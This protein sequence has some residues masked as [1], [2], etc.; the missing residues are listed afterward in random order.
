MYD[1]LKEQDEN[2]NIDGKAINFEETLSNLPND[3][4]G[5]NS[6]KLFAYI[7]RKLDYTDLVNIMTFNYTSVFDRLF[8][9]SKL[10]IHNTLCGEGVGMTNI[11][12]VYHAHGILGN[13]PIFGVSSV[14]QLSNLMDEEVTEEFIK[15]KIIE[16]CLSTANQDNAQ[17]INLADLIII[18][19]MSIGETDGYIWEK[20]ARKSINSGI[21][22]VIY[23]YNDKFD[24]SHPSN[25]KNEVNNV[26]DNFIKNANVKNMNLEEDNIKK[27]RDN[28]LIAINRPIFEISGIKNSV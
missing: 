16:N 6:R 5:L 24:S 19:G 17:L 22:I 27:L 9:R 15:E 2:F 13:N 18:F 10:K 28:I 3:L 7:N 23:Q 21:P 8:K 1:Y 25:T 12:E 4:L 20:I 26:K 14:E 11:V